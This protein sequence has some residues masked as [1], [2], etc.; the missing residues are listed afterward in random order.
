MRRLPIKPL[1]TLILFFVVS[2]ASGAGTVGYYRQPA[3]SQDGIVFVA[4]GD[5]WKVSDKGGD[6]KRLTS[7]VGDESLPAVSPDGKTLAFAGHTTD[8][9]K[10]VPCRSP[11]A[12]RGAVL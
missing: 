12:H 5:L 1:T 3:L 11:A 10:S 8:P 6:A 7:N 2:T 4:E 9:P